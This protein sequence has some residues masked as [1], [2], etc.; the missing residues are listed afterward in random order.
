MLSVGGT[1]QCIPCRDMLFGTCMITCACGRVINLLTA[2]RIVNPAACNP[3]ILLLV[4]TAVH[5]VDQAW[6]LVIFAVCTLCCQGI[7]GMDYPSHLVRDC[8]IGCDLTKVIFWFGCIGVTSWGLGWVSRGAAFF[9]HQANVIINASYHQIDQACLFSR[10][11][12]DLSF[13]C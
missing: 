6:V 2:H 4:V 8:D 10:S 13:D 3:D 1:L 5:M 12:V 7:A 11:L 9:E